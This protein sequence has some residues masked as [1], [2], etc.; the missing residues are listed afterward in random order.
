MSACLRKSGSEK[1]A[2]VDSYTNV[3]TSRISVGQTQTPLAFSAVTSDGLDLGI[4]H[5]VRDEIGAGVESA[6]ASAR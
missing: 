3:E 6:F 5:A 1:N 4:A 2:G